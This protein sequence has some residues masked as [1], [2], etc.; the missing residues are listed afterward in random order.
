MAFEVGSVVEGKVTGIT[1]FGAFIELSNGKTGLCHISEV[2]DNYVKS[3]KDHLQVNQEVKVKIIGLDD[4]GKMN[5]SIK[6]SVEKSNSKAKA[7]T[8]TKRKTNNYSK[9]NEK[10][11]YK[12][13]KKSFSARP[14]NDF[15]SRNKPRKATGFEDLLSD[16]IKDSDDKQRTLKK[17]MKSTRRGNG[18]NGKR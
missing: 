4:K 14:S 15:S 5:L 3:V 11:N 7:L 8:D 13:N 1:N 18:F 9:S 10:S 6:K 2:A 17:N 16:F 12:S